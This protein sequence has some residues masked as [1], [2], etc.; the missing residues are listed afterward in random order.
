MAQNAPI[1]DMMQGGA[2]KLMPPRA[3]DHGKAK[4]KIHY[5]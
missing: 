1:T 4:A 5:C 2:L 3:V